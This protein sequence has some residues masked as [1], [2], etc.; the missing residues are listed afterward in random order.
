MENHTKGKE[1][2]GGGKKISH[3]LEAHF[4]RAG[5]Y[6]QVEEQGL[7]TFTATVQS[8]RRVSCRDI[9]FDYLKGQSSVKYSIVL[10]PTEKERAGD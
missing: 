5:H 6:V 7:F 8:G 4:L 3:K 10:G 1:K 9:E 2:T